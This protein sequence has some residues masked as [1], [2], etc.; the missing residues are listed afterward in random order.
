MAPKPSSTLNPRTTHYEFLGPPGALFVTVTVPLLSYALYFGCSEEFGGCPPP[1][2]TIPPLLSQALS[3]P[4]SWKALWDTQATLLYLAWYAFCIVAWY[5][6]PG[7]WVEGVTLRTGEKKKYKINGAHGHPCSG[8]VTS[9]NHF[10][11]YSLFYIL[12]CSGPHGR[13]Y[14]ALWPFF[15]HFPIREVGW[16]R[17]RSVA[18]VDIPRPC[19]L[20]CVLPRRRAVSVG[21]KLRKRHI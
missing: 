8:L 5:V 10:R 20:R 1:L 18:H 7:D 19:V 4:S 9:V 21:R 15:I 3:T 2:A 14:R 17:Y 11:E 12:A 16:I 6:L 13:S